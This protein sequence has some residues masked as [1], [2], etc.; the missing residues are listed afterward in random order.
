MTGENRTSAEQ[1][2][3][4]LAGVSQCAMLAQE[5]ARRGH[6][7]PEPMRCAL[8]SILILNEI[9]VDTALGGVEGIFAGLPDLGRLQPDPA[10]VERLRYAIALI[11]LQKRLRREK[12]I[13][14]E[15]RSL[16]VSLRDDPIAEDPVSTEAVKAF[17]EI[18]TAT[19][20]TL[21]PKIMVRGEQ[22][23]LKNDDTVSKVRA[24]LLAGVRSAYLFHEHGGRKW[25][26]F[27]GRKRL[28][29]AARALLQSH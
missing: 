7:Q 23:H 25:H 20:S 18:Y 22:Q 29:A 6:A 5:L 1:R 28:A 2:V 11:D 9:N 19:V 4:A 14:G 12:E 27:I 8:S 17:A 24:V 10:A 16:L 13:G 26:L 21:T 3:L 15:L